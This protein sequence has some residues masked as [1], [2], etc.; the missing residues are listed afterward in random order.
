M[1]HALLGIL[2]L[3]AALTAQAQTAAGVEVV[4][5]SVTPDTIDRG[6]QIT[7]QWDVRGLDRVSI[8][9]FYGGYR[10]PAD[11]VYQDLPGR[12]R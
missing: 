12:V 3:L 5:F 10:S 4:E 7:L 6:G 9:Q 2:L 1:R 8:Y 11:V